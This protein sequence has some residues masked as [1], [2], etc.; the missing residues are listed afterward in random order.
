MIDG[1]RLRTEV[2]GRIPRPISLNHVILGQNG[3]I[4]CHPQK[5]FQFLRVLALPD[6][7]MIFA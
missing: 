4:Y 3:V 2:A 1:L 7:L 6:H 5:Y